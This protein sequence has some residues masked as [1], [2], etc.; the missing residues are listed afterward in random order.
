[1]AGHSG[2][3]RNGAAHLEQP[4]NPFVSQVM[5]MEVFDFQKLAGSGESGA[6]RV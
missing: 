5:K 3:L 6:D 1:M 2:D 4:G